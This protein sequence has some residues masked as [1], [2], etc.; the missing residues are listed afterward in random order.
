VAKGAVVK[1]WGAVAKGW[2]AKGWAKGWVGPGAGWAIAGNVA[3]RNGATTS[4]EVS[5][6][7]AVCVRTV[8][9]PSAKASIEERLR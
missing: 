6:N 1:G 2:G 9:C 8:S 5:R 4:V 7:K 3:N